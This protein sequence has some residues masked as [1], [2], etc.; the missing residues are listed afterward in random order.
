MND[1]TAA[2]ARNRRRQLVAI[3]ALVFMADQ[4]SKY[5]LLE[6]FGIALK[7]PVRLSENFALVM[8][9]NRGVSFSMFTHSAVWMPY[10][11]T[12][13]AVAI[14]ALLV[15]LC[16]KSPHRLERVGYAMIVG[17]ALG[18][19]MDRL[20]FGAVADFFY[21]HIGP[22]GWP[23]FNVADMA[24]CCGVGLLLLSLVKQPARP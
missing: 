13:V 17:G 21:A 11:L 24:I 1:M 10:L 6:V 4:L 8:A 23:A 14:S 15:R 5:W 9:W 18:N 12:A 3:A 20:R 22:Y 2:P 16:L 19:A 7:A